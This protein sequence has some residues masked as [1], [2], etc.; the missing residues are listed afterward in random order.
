VTDALVEIEVERHRQGVGSS[1][2]ERAA[3]HHASGREHATR[4]VLGLTG[5]KENTEGVTRLFLV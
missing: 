2:R 4:L 1:P 3:R 5:V